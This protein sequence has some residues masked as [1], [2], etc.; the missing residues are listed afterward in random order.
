[1]GDIRSDIDPL[2]VNHPNPSGSQPLDDTDPGIH[3]DA[4]QKVSAFGDLWDGIMAIPG[5]IRRSW[6]YVTASKARQYAT[7]FTVFVAMIALAAIG[8]TGDKV[9][10]TQPQQVVAAGS[11]VRTAKLGDSWIAIAV[12]NNI[13]DWHILVDANM[14]L[15][16]AN[17]TWC[18][19]RTIKGQPIS[20]NYLAGLRI[21]GTPRDDD[22]C[23]LFPYKGETLAITTLREKQRY[24]LPKAVSATAVVNNVK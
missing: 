14:D 17:T 13:A 7:A 21:D 19:N 9:V 1:M 3:P 11:D 5:Q 23:V 20:A 6:I 24:N 22:Y 8:L 15:V 16:R 18:Q 12:V 10:E 4:A 2:N